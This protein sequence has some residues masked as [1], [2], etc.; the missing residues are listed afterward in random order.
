MINA[1]T[2]Y[3]LPGGR[4][5]RSL[6]QNDVELYLNIDEVTCLVMYSELAPTKSIEH[7]WH[8]VKWAGYDTTPVAEGI[9]EVN[10]K[11]FDFLIYETPTE[12]KQ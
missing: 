1:D 5:F 2:F 8:I 12:E 7:M 10:G 4:Y 3:D 6:V 9:M 11:R